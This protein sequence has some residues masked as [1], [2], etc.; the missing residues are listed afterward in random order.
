MKKK[1][2]FFSANFVSAII[3]CVL[4]ALIARRFSRSQTEINHPKPTDSAISLNLEMIEHR[5]GN[6]RREFHI[7]SEMITAYNDLDAGEN[8]IDR[9]LLLL[10]AIKD[11]INV[12]RASGLTPNQVEGAI[13]NLAVTT[14]SGNINEN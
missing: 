9:K 6:L 13:L 8:R 3:L 11:R 10:N 7:L 12:L 1:R 5:D 4:L 14:V 2:S